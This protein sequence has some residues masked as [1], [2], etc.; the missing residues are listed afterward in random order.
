MH[1]QWVLQIRELRKFPYLTQFCR[2]WAVPHLESW[3][4]SNTDF[5]SLVY[6]SSNLLSNAKNLSEPTKIAKI[7]VRKLDFLSSKLHFLSSMSFITVY[8]IEANYFM[9]KSTKKRV[10]EVLFLRFLSFFIN[11]WRSKV[12]K[13]NDRFVRESGLLHQYGSF[14]TRFFT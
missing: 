4:Y 6:N 8:I 12:N 3:L 13:R 5:P 14:C 10:F 7:E 1:I 9:T 11:F 2:K